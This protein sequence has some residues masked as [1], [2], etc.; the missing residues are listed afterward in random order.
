L[1]TTGALGELQDEVPGMPDQAPAGLDDP[2]LEARQR[3]TLNR[4]GESEP[5]Q[6]MDELLDATDPLGENSDRLRH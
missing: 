3:P 5:T 6:E 2:Q 4:K 1:S